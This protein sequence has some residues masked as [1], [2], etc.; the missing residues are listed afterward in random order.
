MRAPPG[1]VLLWKGAAGT[2]PGANLRRYHPVSASPAA[3]AGRL[4]QFDL[5]VDAGGEIELHQRV[6]RLRRRLHDVEQPL[7]GPHLELL[8]RLLVD[9][10]RA[11]DGELLDA[12][13]QRN[14][15]ADQST[16]ATRRVGDVASGLVEHSMIERLQANAD[17]LRFHNLLTDC[18]E[19]T[20]EGEPNKTDRTLAA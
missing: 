18:K 10:R 13:R 3:R 2:Q 19:P 9:V 8:A 6:D 17:V 20:P 1:L 4:S 12:R 14:G 11:V 5:H 15:A 16:R 7:I